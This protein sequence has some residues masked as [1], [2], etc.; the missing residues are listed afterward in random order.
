MSDFE[1]GLNLR[2]YR[3]HSS[4]KTLINIKVDFFRK[5]PIRKTIFFPA[6]THV[7]QRLAP[8]KK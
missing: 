7:A 3:F 5:H 2:K 8:V 6:V 1:Y 4:E